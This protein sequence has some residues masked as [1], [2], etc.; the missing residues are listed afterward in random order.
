MVRMS[1]IWKELPEDLV[2]HILSYN[3]KPVFFCSICNKYKPY[4]HTHYTYVE[5]V[6]F[7]I[8]LYELATSTNFLLSFCILICLYLIVFLILTI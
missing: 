5:C 8:D 1:I 3:K 2:D 7:F 4:S 6:M